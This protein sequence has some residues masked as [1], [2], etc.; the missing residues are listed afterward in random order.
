M[1]RGFKH[2]D[3]RRASALTKKRFFSHLRD[4]LSRRRWEI[5]G[6]SVFPGFFSGS[7]PRVLGRDPDL[8]SPES[9]P[10]RSSQRPSEAWRRGSEPCFWEISGER[11]FLRYF[12]ESRPRALA[13]DSDLRSPKSA[14]RRSIAAARGNPGNRRRTKKKARP[15][16][17]ALV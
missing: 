9:A 11:A 6:V 4:S 12:S 8:R 5:P 15:E 16:G 7:R 3:P 10:G 17:R 14:P 1:P 2:P 13:H